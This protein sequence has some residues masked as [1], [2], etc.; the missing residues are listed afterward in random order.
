MLCKTLVKF[1]EDSGYRIVDSDC[2]E[3]LYKFVARRSL[4]STFV[5]A[6][7][8]YDNFFSVSVDGSESGDVLILIRGDKLDC[9]LP[10]PIT[11]FDK[12]FDLCEPNSL[13]DII[14]HLEKIKCFR[15]HN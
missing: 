14:D 8:Y 13:Q 2:G 9:E 3:L 7:A 4:V 6:S 15:N 11:K 5:G 1:L 12:T 10:E